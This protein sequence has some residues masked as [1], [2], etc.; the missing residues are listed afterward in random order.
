VNQDLRLSRSDTRWNFVALVVDTASWN[1]TFSFTGLDSVIP[2]LV[3]QLTDSAP[4]IGLVGTVYTAGWMLP[5]L[6]IARMINEKPRKKPYLVAGLSGRVMFWGIALALWAGLARDPT[7]MLALFFTLLG[8]FA[9]TDSLTTVAL[10]DVMS[11]ALPARQRGRMFGISQV[12]SGLAGIG[13]GVVVGSIL[14]SPR[15][16][17]PFNYALLFALAGAAI[18]PST[19]ALAVVREPPPGETRQKADVPGRMAWLKL[20]VTDPGFLRMIV[21]QMLVTMVQ[22]ASPFFAVHAS[23]VLNLPQSIVGSFVIALAVAGVVA[24][25]VLGLVSERWGPHYVIRIGS[26]IAMT[27]PIFALIA[28]LSGGGP[29]AQAYP[30][31]FIALG[32]VNSIRMLGFRNYLMGIAREGMRPAYIGMTN[33]ISGLLTLT[34]MLGGW[35]LETTSY[36]TLFGVTAVVVGI[37]FVLSLT[38]KPPPPTA[39]A[40]M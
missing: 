21:C 22:L 30:V 20:L 4:V 26:G 10:F 33:T 24:S 40:G 32:T 37:G 3:S 27:G 8:L 18:I 16:P 39:S 9:V 25:A 35:L 34:P 31:V 14:A 7:A 29:L 23:E 1:A 19:V 17:F 36:A 2:L 11:R 28:H 12:I 6:A 5:Q 15:L 38:L 13:I